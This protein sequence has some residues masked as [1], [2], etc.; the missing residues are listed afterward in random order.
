V[1]EPLLHLDDFG[2][3]LSC[4]LLVHHYHIACMYG[5]HVMANSVHL[6]H[7]TVCTMV[8]VALP[9]CVH[10]HAAWYGSFH[11]SG[12]QYCSY[13]CW[14]LTTISY[15]CTPVHAS[16]YGM[17]WLVPHAIHRL[18]FSVVQCSI[19]TLLVSSTTIQWP[20]IVLGYTGRIVNPLTV[21][22]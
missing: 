7:S 19:L 14:C 16:W 18:Y 13:Y 10:V 8:G 22:V 21:I 20:C 17:V 3:G 9:Y 15:A 6:V 4:L 5:L 11:T 12:V 2:D 1:F